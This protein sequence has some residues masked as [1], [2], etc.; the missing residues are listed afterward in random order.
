M[1]NKYYCVSGVVT[2]DDKVLFVRHTYGTA[3]GRIL[4]PGGFVKENEMPHKAAEREIF[5]ETGITA[6][7]NSILSVQFKPE[8]WCIIFLMDYICGTPH[9]DNS[10][11]NEVLLL[12]AE[13]AVMRDDITNLSKRIMQTIMDKNFAALN[14]SDYTAKTSNPDEYLIFGVV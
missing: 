7:V 12:S 8:Q 9:S 1:N 4:I 13:D 3:K 11:N 2:I 14:K 5:E 6:K 10:E